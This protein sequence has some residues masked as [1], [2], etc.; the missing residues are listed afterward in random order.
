VA[1]SS[2]AVAEHKPRVEALAWR[3]N[4]L[5]GAEFD[6]LVQEGLIKVWLL[7]EESDDPGYIPANLVIERAMLDWVRVCRRQGF[8]N[9]EPD[10]T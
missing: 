1:V 4:G 5:G 7:L 8:S 3:F 10:E 9:R 2:E 6:D